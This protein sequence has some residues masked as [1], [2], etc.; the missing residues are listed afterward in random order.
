[1]IY[2]YSQYTAMLRLPDSMPIPEKKKRV[3][4]IIDALDLRKCLK[5]SKVRKC[6]QSLFEILK[7]LSDY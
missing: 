2:L 7:L 4:R 3:D 1:M 6:M 5:T